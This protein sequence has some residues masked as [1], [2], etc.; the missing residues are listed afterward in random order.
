MENFFAPFQEIKYSPSNMNVLIWSIYCIYGNLKAS[1]RILKV[2]VR[3]LSAPI[4]TLKRQNFWSEAGASVT[5][6]WEQ[7]VKLGAHPVTQVNEN[8]VDNLDPGGG[9]STLAALLHPGFATSLS[10]CLD[11][12]MQRARVKLLYTY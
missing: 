11:H 1:D 5:E 9:D 8:V 7:I 12:S 6:I 2:C 3:V 4:G 10:L